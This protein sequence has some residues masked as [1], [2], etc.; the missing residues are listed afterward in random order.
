[1]PTVYRRNATIEAA[2]MQGESILFDAERNRFCLLNST[3][4]FVWERLAQPMTVEAL[5]AELC[6]QFSTPEPARVEADVRAALDKFAELA[7][8]TTDSAT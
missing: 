7:L 4:A 1:M 6:R 8:L 3:A 5:S 2:P